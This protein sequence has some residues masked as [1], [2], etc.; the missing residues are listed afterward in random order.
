MHLLCIAM[1]LSSISLLS[2][3]RKRQIGNVWLS[4]RAFD[5]HPAAGYLPP[6]SVHP[7]R[8]LLCPTFDERLESSPAGSGGAAPRKQRAVGWDK[9]RRSNL[10]DHDGRR[11]SSARQLAEGAQ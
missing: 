2:P 10:G 3:G 8:V 1:P 7:D 6:R 11:R 5:G 9:K 4:G